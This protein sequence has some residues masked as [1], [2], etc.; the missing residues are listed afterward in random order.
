MIRHAVLCSLLLA[1]P[2]VGQAQT[3]DPK[4]MTPIARTMRIRLTKDVATI[5]ITRVKGAIL[6][7]AMIADKQVKLL[8]DNGSDASVIDTSLARDNVLCRA[9]AAVFGQQI[10]MR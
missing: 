2:T 8:F 3:P 1:V 4:A 10:S 9:A 7:P 5:P 6:V